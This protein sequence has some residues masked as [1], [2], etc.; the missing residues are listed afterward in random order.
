MPINIIIWRAP[1]PY[2]ACP[3]Q[4]FN[5]VGMLKSASTS[6]ITFAQKIL[7]FSEKSIILL[8]MDARIV[9]VSISKHR[10]I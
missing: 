6:I 10:R 2:G 9:G 1:R 7:T 5:A 8:I 4:P 3:T